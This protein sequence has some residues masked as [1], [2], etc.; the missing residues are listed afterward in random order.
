[1]T[2]FKTGLTQAQVEAHLLKGE[3]N[4]ATTSAS[5]TTKEIILHNT[6]TLFNFLNLL[7][8]CM[9]LFT[10][11]LKN[12][13]FILSV[14]F[15][16]GIGIYQEIKA[17]KTIESLS[18]LKQAKVL[19]LR[20]GIE[21]QVNKEDIVLDDILFLTK[22]MQVPVDVRSLEEGLVVDESL[23][24]GES[25][26]IKKH[27]GD[28]IY[29]GSLV[30]QGNT[31]VQV[32]SV[33]NNTYVSKLTV[34][35][36]AFAMTKSQIQKNIDRILKWITII[37]LPAT[38]AVFLDQYNFLEIIGTNA[39]ILKA[40][41]A[42]IGIMPEG[43]VLL[44]SVALAAGVLKLSTLGTLTQELPAIET[45]AR[46]DTI[47][48]DKTGTITEGKMSVENVL[49]YGDNQSEIDDIIAFIVSRDAEQ[50]MS[51]IAL[52]SKF[53][54]PQKTYDVVD[55]LPF[56]SELK[57][58]AMEIAG[59][60]TYLLGAFD[61]IVSELPAAVKAD[62]EQYLK[63]GNR[64]IGLAHSQGHLTDKGVPKDASL[65]ALILIKDVV[66]EDARDIIA[67]FKSQDVDV[68]IISGDYP[69]T[70]A[71][72]AKDV[73]VTGK[74]IISADI[75][76]DMATLQRV[77]K[78]TSIFGRVTPPQKRNIIQALQKNGHTTCMVGDGINDILALK[79]SDCAI[80]FGSG[81]EATKAVAKF[82]LLENDF[83]TLPNVVKEGRKV[84]NNI[85]TVASLHV[86]R[87]IYSTILVFAF[88]LFKIL[89]PLDPVNLTL[90]GIL[91][92]GVP[93][94]L[95]VF[96]K[97]EAKAKD[98]FFR[99]IFLNA[100]PCSIVLALTIFTLGALAKGEISI[101]DV[102]GRVLHYQHYAQ[103]EI[104]DMAM[105]TTITQVVGG[106][107]IFLM[108]L[109]CRP[110]TRFRLSVILL[111]LV[112]F[113]ASYFI[114]PLMSLFGLSPVEF[115]WP[116]MWY[117]FLTIIIVLIDIVAILIIRFILLKTVLKEKPK[118]IEV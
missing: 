9:V 109:L 22:G 77:V 81:S 112:T 94:F 3:V 34:E 118:E 102:G 76:E 52:Q 78:E 46:V 31:K 97:N 107:Q 8:F 54:T 37:I 5:R 117:D 20:D 16:T 86:V 39:V 72:I 24:T 114:A 80:A 89:F 105:K 13:L 10:G 83:S 96:E 99:N 11:S 55:Y 12:L 88:F 50:N 113:I 14:V 53:Q 18:I 42:M 47:C 108:F 36:K 74:A 91:T 71:A 38:I 59:Q 51:T 21:T 43:L 41:A 62:I 58:Q 70:V 25:E 60:G 90:V 29:S 40:V 4:I 19:V 32:I 116:P 67:Y 7:L 73:G 79:Q 65:L 15:N 104:L 85:N 45:L 27:I 64:I 82:V 101:E 44:T 49:Y 6:L 115:Y 95:L 63:S 69:D 110:L 17:K 84:I 23:I 93:T 66:K 33:G 48:L 92:I 30:M 57:L 98:N 87:V 28:E 106:V 75:P 103:S 56:S 1:M 100:L 35:A 68:K 61:M 2:D 26:F 111:S